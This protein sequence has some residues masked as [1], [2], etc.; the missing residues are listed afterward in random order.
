MNF[1]PKFLPILL[2]LLADLILLFFVYDDY[3]IGWDENSSRDIGVHNALIANEKT[4]YLLYPKADLES[5]IKEKLG[6]TKQSEYL[7]QEHLQ[8][9]SYSMYGPA[10]ELALVGL[11]RITGL[12]QDRELYLF[13]HISTHLF[14]LSGI[15]VFYLLLFY[16]FQDWKIGLLGTIMLLLIPRLY[17]HSFFNP[18]D[19]PFLVACIFATYSMFRFV[20]KPG[21]FPAII[22]GLICALA[23]DIRIIGLLFPLITIGLWGTE[24]FLLRKTQGKEPFQAFKYLLVYGISISLFVILFWPYLWNNP[25]EHLA[26]SFKSMSNYPWQGSLL[27]LG[28]IY[29]P[30]EYLPFSFYPVWFSIITPPVFFIGFLFSFFRFS[31]VNFSALT[32]ERKIDRLH[33]TSILLFILPGL[34][35]ILLKSVLYDDCRHFFFVYPFFIIMTLLGFLWVKQKL[36]GRYKFKTIYFYGGMAIFLLPILVKMVMLHP[37]EYVYFNGLA[38]KDIEKKFETDYWGISY[39]EGFDYILEAEKASGNIKIIMDDSLLSPVVYNSFL[40]KPEQLEQIEWVNDI[41]KADYFMTTYRCTADRREHLKQWHIDP[42]WEVD[43]IHA[44]GI[45]ILSVFNIQKE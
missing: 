36:E 45:K 44:G 17:P 23:I 8:A 7:N 34:S 6:E 25:L 29:T 16:H 30:V 20:D 1:K 5:R 38:G 31:R 28:K 19:I 14:F 39:K 42:D 21:M 12:N 3:G 40:L 13:R 27:F 15:F 33:L 4:G 43:S 10:F 18:K 35:A 32:S 37:F 41:S 22:H 26:W 2:L 11:E 9:Y 24:I